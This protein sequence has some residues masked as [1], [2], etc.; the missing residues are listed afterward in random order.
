MDCVARRQ[1]DAPQVTW[2][3]HG[4]GHGV[5]RVPIRH[6]FSDSTTRKHESALIYMGSKPAPLC[7]YFPFD[8]SSIAPHN[9]RIDDLAPPRSWS[10]ARSSP[11]HQAALVRSRS[12]GIKA[13]AEEE[14]LDKHFHRRG[15]VARRRLAECASALKPTSCRPTSAAQS[16]SIANFRGRQG[17]D[18]AP[19]W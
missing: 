15:S 17:K 6:S 1:R 11:Q 2:G 19:T 4:M 8:R 16:T 18:S 3:H 12:R 14:G 10:A 9:S 7:G 5:T 13:Q